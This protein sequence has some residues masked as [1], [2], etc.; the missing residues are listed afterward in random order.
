MV[1]YLLAFISS[2]SFGISNAY[3]RIPQKT[4]G[5]SRLVFFRGIV[6]S[7]FFGSILL[8]FN[9]NAYNPFHL[10]VFNATVEDYGITFMLCLLCSLGLV[11]YLMSLKHSRVSISVPLTSLNI[12]GVLTALFVL[13]EPFFFRYCFSFPL[14][15]LGVVCTQIAPG[16]GF[17]LQW[18]K[19]ATYSLLASF[20]W[21]VSYALFKYSVRWIG[22]LPLAFVLETSVSVLALVWILINRESVR[23]S[24]WRNP[25]VAGHCLFLAFLLINGTI[26]CCMALQSIPVLAFNCIS[27]LQIV[28]AVLFD[29]LFFKQIPSTTEFT[30]IS[31]ILLSVV[32][33][34]I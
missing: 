7:A 21:G 29:I 23:F 16:K 12:F 27:Y 30:G 9:Y 26:C 5:F 17:R 32:V 11:M 8:L 33:S 3:W 22:P 25:E 20:F 10:I 1:G 15:F 19:G 14:A 31:L 4:I 6:A 2:L 13:K 34:Q 24:Q 28:V 18:N